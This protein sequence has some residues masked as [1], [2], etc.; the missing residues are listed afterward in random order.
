L[1]ISNRER[2]ERREGFERSMRR[3]APDFRWPADDPYPRSHTAFEELF[4]AEDDKLWV[5]VVVGST[6]SERSDG[7]PR[8]RNEYGFDVFSADGQFERHVRL[9][10]RMTMSARPVF[11]GDSVWA[12]YTDATGVPTLAH[13]VVR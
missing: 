8:W 10:E 4:A 13:F 3:E 6:R 9:P 5:L 2:R 11:R 7:T 1:E 12:S